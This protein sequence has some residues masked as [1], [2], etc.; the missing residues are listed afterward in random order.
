MLKYEPRYDLQS[1][2]SIYSYNSEEKTQD[3]S[4]PKMIINR[5]NV[6]FPVQFL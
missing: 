5:I 2:M 4:I 3:F 1:K 6:S